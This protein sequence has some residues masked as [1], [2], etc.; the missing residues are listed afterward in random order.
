MIDR[1]FIGL[2]V[3]PEYCAIAEQRI[4]QEVLALA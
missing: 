4:A 1:Q 3:N 2:E